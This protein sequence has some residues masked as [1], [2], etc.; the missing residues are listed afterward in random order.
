MTDGL[1]VLVQL[2]I[3]AIATEPFPIS[4][5]LPSNSISTFL[6]KSFPSPRSSS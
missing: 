3:A 6:F 5:F 4:S 1:E 2:V